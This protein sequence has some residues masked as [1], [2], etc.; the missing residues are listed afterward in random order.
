MVQ[1][2][3]RTEADNALLKGELL[4]AQD[5][6]DEAQTVLMAARKQDPKDL[7]VWTTLV[8][9]LLRSNRPERVGALLDMAAKEVGDAFPLRLERIRVITRQ[10]GET[11]IAELE[12]M[13]Q[14]LEKLPQ[15]QRISLMLQLGAAHLQL[16]NY[17]G[18]K[19]CWTYVMEHDDKNA[20]I[21]QVLLE[22]MSDTKDEAGMKAVLANVRDARNWG[23]QSA[24]YKYG[25]AMSL[26]RPI[27]SRGQ[28]PQALSDAD[29]KA[30]GDAR[31][32]ITEA[33]ALRREWGVL[34]RVR[35]E[36]DQLEGK[37]D[38]AIANYQHALECNTTG[39]TIVARRL[40][41]L[42]SARRRFAEADK[43]LK[44]VGRL[45]A[46]DPLQKLSRVIDIET[47]DIDAA[48]AGAEKD[49]QTDPKNP[50]NH[51]FYG[52]LLEQA[53]RS[54]DAERAFRKAVEVGPDLPQAWQLLVQHLV[55][56]K[57]TPEAVEV[58]RDATPRLEKNPIALASLYEAAGD[59][60]QAEHFYQAALEANPD[61]LVALRRIVTF[62]FKSARL[63]GPRQSPE[64]IKKAGPYLE[65]VVKKTSGTTDA[66][67]VRELGWA[68]R[69]QAEILAADGQY[70]NVVKATKLI[71][72][73]AIG[74]KFATE[75]LVMLIA[76]L[77][78]RTE[79]E[80]RARSIRLLEQLRQ[81]RP[82]QPREELLLGQLHE[83]AG[84]WPAAK[85]LM[86]KSLTRQAND[87]ETLIAFSQSLIRHGEND[88]AG[89]WLDKV[90]DLL[91]KVPPRVMEQFRPAA[92]ELRAR[93]LVNTG[94]PEK[95]VAVL[96]Q[97]VPSPLPPRELYRLE[98]VSR[99]LEQLGQYDAARKLLDEYFAQEPRGAIALAAFLGRRG[100]IDKAFE[101]LEE[102]RKNQSVTEILPCA[103]EALRLYPQQATPERFKLLEDWAKAGLQAEP[104]APQIKLLLAEIVRPAGPLPGSG[105]DVPRS[106]GHQGHHFHASGDRQEQ[107]GVHSGRNQ[108]K[109]TRG[110]EAYRRIDWGD[111]PE[112]RFARHARRRLSR[113]RELED[114]D[115][116]SSRQRERFAIDGQVFPPRSSRK[117]SRQSRRGARR[118]GT[119]ATARRRSDSL[120]PAGTEELRTVGQRAEVRR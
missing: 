116:G 38:E 35:A 52:Q 36:V 19:R 10:G 62:Y 45:S 66:A 112:L 42:L 87:V 92:R 88:D 100:E 120:D 49:V 60:D 89:R 17:D 76:L 114:G 12:K 93:L 20:Q 71:E 109:R 85:E 33:L 54:D 104:D 13:E 103:L 61:D 23:P 68:R 16:R 99:L 77:S 72:Q 67:S 96:E 83:R 118:D 57:K 24:L 106:S 63:M 28:S 29:R 5:R 111:G 4:I 78:K 95:A 2:P 11:A 3:A 64:Q 90:D 47:G 65:R 6:L 58:I 80:S 26:V 46:T 40:V 79:P 41:Q 48:L 113:S 43:A 101:L 1:D 22:L 50:A 55:A 8:K 31:R 27:S 39:Q 108:T 117:A 44:Y 107:P 69:T 32:L 102:S 30:L 119:S 21:R 9:L 34:W 59:H 94:Q 110:A 97:L 56:H 25:L 75:D 14:D 7:R 53:A 81:L 91:S 105:K 115:R 98:E 73:N 84:N 18:S 37:I 15:P 82:L 70:D 86:V 74:G 51:I